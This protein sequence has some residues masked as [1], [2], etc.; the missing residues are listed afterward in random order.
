MAQS[1]DTHVG[2]V[3]RIRPD[4]SAPPDNPFVANG[5]LPEVWSIGHRNPQGATRGP[6][7][8]LWTV[9][10]G[11]RGGDE[12]NRAD[13]GQNHGWPTISYG[14]HYSGTRIGE[15]TAKAGME[16]PRAY[17]TPSIA[18]AGAMIY[19]G[20]LFPGWKGDLFTGSLKYGFVS[21][22]DAEDLAPGAINV[23][24]RQER[25]LDDMLIRVRDVREGPD[26]AIWFL[27]EGEGALFRMT[28]AG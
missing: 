6:G 13:A 14:V 21:R 27:D 28:P 23:W 19:S 20:R 4:G 9:S 3:I 22:V 24:D 17:W 12:V 25:L 15:G 5:A 2:K 10:H 18:P 16:Q 7:G 1:R 11:A 8:A 26:G